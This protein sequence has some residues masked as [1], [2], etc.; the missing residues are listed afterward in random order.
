MD[1]NCFK[2]VITQSPVLCCPK[3]DRSCWIAIDAHL[4]DYCID[5]MS[6]HVVT[7][8]DG[9]GFCWGSICKVFHAEC[10]VG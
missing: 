1:L 5:H 7:I 4:G 3:Y 8:L 9:H 2:V 10:V 6:L